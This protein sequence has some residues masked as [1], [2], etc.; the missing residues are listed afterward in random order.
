MATRGEILRNVLNSLQTMQVTVTE[1]F[2]FVLVHRQFNAPGDIL[3]Q[4]IIA[5][6]RVFLSAL[7]HNPATMDSTFTWTQELTRTRLA[8]TVSNMARTSEDLCFG[9][10]SAD[11]EQV[12]EFRLEDMAWDLQLRAPDVWNLVVSLL[13]GFDRSETQAPAAQQPGAIG[14]TA[15][16]PDDNEYWGGDDSLDL[17]TGGAGTDGT[18]ADVPRDRVTD[19]RNL[20]VHI[21]SVV[22]ISIL[23]HN[24]NQR[25]NALQSVI[26]I[27][28]HSCGAPEKLIKVLSRSGLS[29]SLPSIHRAVQ[30]LALHSAETVETLGQSLLASYAFDNLDTKLP[31]G[32]VPTI[33]GVS[34]GLIHI[35]TGTVFR[36]NHGV[37]LEDLRCS[38]LLWNRSP[39]NPLAADP[40]PYDSE[41][42]VAHLLG[43]HPEPE[44]AADALSRRGRF[45]AWFAIEAL[46]KYGPPHFTDLRGG[47]RE[48]ETVEKIPVKKLY[49]TPLR[50]MDISLSTVSGNLEALGAM[51]AQGG[52]GDPRENPLAPNHAIRDLSEYVTIIHGDLGTVEKVD[53]A[54][55]RRKQERTPYNRLQHVVMVPGLFHLKMAS[56]DAIW[57]MLVLPDDARID[58]GSFNKLIGQLRPD[59]SSR[60]ISNSKFRE[61]HDLINHIGTLL[62]LDA[63]QVEVQRRWGF[64]TLEEWAESKP[65]VADVEDTARSLIQ[66]HVEGAGQNM[67]AVQE[68]FAGQRDKVKENT[69]RT[70]NYLL[71]YEELSFAMNAGDIGRMETLLVS[72]ISIFR[73]VGKHKYATYML[74]FMHA[75]H[76][77]Y[78]EGL[79]RAIRYN[80]LVN[81]TGKPHAFRA[82]DWL[83]ELLNLY[84]KIIYGGDGSNYTKERILIESILVLV[85]RSS[86]ANVERNFRIP[87]LTNKHAE[88]NMRATFT[89]ILDGYLKKYGPNKYNAGRGT[90]YTIPNRIERG[91]EIFTTD[92][93]VKGG[94]GIRTAAAV[95]ADPLVPDDDLL[96]EITV[97]DLSTDDFL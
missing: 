72:W 14:N 40:R 93:L 88:K 27:F 45:R 35:T 74:R 71:L 60:L 46:C 5:N 44:Y 84:I 7:Y 36:L 49:Q 50:A 18:S 6:A 16:D 70:L 59:D 92:W 73:A 20:L 13:G 43:L 58:H 41:A 62:L 90:S 30:S 86:H 29:I 26:G 80:M 81:P 22:I 75:L 52:V 78:P 83:V 31:T 94:E 9:A 47:L 57:R 39:S 38:D 24:N 63:W 17:G 97:E 3:Y 61:R 28:L 55:R 11:P 19:R 51:L 85:F 33:D 67:W 68:K 89:D 64:D 10:A 91:S 12:Y 54:M 23:L 65:A 53:I 4:D 32:S 8:K 1:L 56:A 66:G 2:T 77:V 21:K 76:L 82:V 79:R 87:G 48:P 96:E 37:V 69:M 95:A 25:C 42:T 34:D 15:D